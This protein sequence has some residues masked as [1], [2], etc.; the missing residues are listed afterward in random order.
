M[1]VIR[2]LRTQQF[3]SSSHL[4]L[5]IADTGKCVPWG[6]GR[7]RCPRRC[8]SEQRPSAQVCLFCGPVRLFISDWDHKFVNA[9]GIWEG[10]R[11]NANY[12]YLRATPNLRATRC[13]NFRS[14]DGFPPVLSRQDGGATF[15]LGQDA[16]FVS[17]YRCP[18][19]GHDLTV[20]SASRL[21]VLSL[22]A[23]S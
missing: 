19:P 12:A 3:D 7:R 9:P 22:R 6:F 10:P 1:R 15:K 14:S 21:G 8:H 5:P 23:V 18:W 20:Q 2:G 4:T 11:R 17:L 13:P 16:F